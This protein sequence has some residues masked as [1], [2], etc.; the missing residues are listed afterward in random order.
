M[1]TPITPLANGTAAGNACTSAVINRSTATPPTLDGNQTSFYTAQQSLAAIDGKPEALAPT[2]WAQRASTLL[3][4]LYDRAVFHTGSA[5]FASEFQDNISLGDVGAY[6]G[7]AAGGG[8]LAYLGIKLYFGIKDRSARH[9]AECYFN[10]ILNII[11]EGDVGERG[12]EL[13]NV[14]KPIY[15][16]PLDAQ[17]I[18]RAFR[19]NSFPRSLAELVCFMYQQGNRISFHMGTLL[20]KH[21]KTQLAFHGEPRQALKA[22]ME[23]CAPFLEKGYD[24]EPLDLVDAWVKSVEKIEDPKTRFDLCMEGASYVCEADITSGLQSLMVTA[25]VAMSEVTDQSVAD[26]MNQRLL[27]M[28]EGVQD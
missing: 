10:S 16:H 28:G 3:S 7:V 18:D 11:E 17:M 21:L 20:L 13:V 27:E 19:S 5:V 22:L 1:S 8:I 26:S 24:G 23:M 25:I 15:W 9:Q 6:V 12:K 14:L 2:T 4:G